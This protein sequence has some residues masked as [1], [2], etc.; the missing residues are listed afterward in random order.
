MSNQNY[1]DKKIPGNSSNGHKGAAGE[2]TSLMSEAANPARRGG[3]SELVAPLVTAFLL[4]VSGTE[5]AHGATSQREHNASSPTSE[6]M[7]RAGSAKAQQV[8]LY[9]IQKGDSLAAIAKR[10]NVSL[11]FLVAENPDAEPKSLSIG[12]TIRIPIQPEFHLIKKGENLDQI[13][14]QYGLSVKALLRANPNVQDPRKLQ[15]GQKLDLPALSRVES[16][17]APAVQATTSTKAAPLATPAL[18]TKQTNSGAHIETPHTATRVSEQSS[19]PAGR[20]L[21]AQEAPT[22]L[23]YL[24]KVLG[25]EGMKISQDKDDLG[26]QG[27]GEITN[28]GITGIAVAD[29]VKTT[30]K[31]DASRAEVNTILKNLTL[32][33]AIVIY[34]TGF[35]RKEYQR[36]PDSLAFMMFDWG[37]NANPRNVIKRFQKH[38]GIKATGELD[39]VTITKINSLGEEKACKELLTCRLNR[40]RERVEENPSQKKYLPG[41]T[42]RAHESLHF[43]SSQKYKELTGVF[44]QTADRGCDFFDPV[45]EGLFVL[46][47][48]SGEA[49]MI[50]LLQ[51]RLG[52]VGYKVEVD[53][54]WGDEMDRTVAF[55]KE[56]HGLP[57]C[58]VKNG[59]PIGVTWGQVDTVV[60]DAKVKTLKQQE[61]Q[62]PLLAGSFADLKLPPR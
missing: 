38:L 54:V 10:F 5:N 3:L 57:P 36:L 17:L 11:E 56:K 34:S 47:R 20:K 55:F 43:A 14:K 45:R 61:N 49:A 27:I 28:A 21:S 2:S 41:W 4:A 31:K 32:E 42:S 35:W 52:K 30:T 13:A 29:H 18:V 19:L 22:F 62:A 15:I 39:E 7:L 24:W 60:L 9:R 12:Q 51:E 23:T 8:S 16:P 46:K 26:N 40:Y 53:G 58:Q 59:K 33:E 48:G 25:F 44:K 37:I 6:K 1:S 50:R